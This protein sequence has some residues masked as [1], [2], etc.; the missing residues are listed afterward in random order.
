MI[1]GANMRSRIANQDHTLVID[2]REPDTAGREI[3]VREHV[4]FQPDQ[5]QVTFVTP[6][7]GVE[8]VATLSLRND[9]KQ[10]LQWSC[11]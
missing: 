11:D 2:P 1:N 5:M 7:G 3:D 9:A 8:T 4:R 10:R 6:H